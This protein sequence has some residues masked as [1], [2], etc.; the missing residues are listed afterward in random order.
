MIKTPMTAGASDR[1]VIQ[2]ASFLNEKERN[3]IAFTL[4]RIL[5]HPGPK[6]PVVNSHDRQV[7]D[8]SKN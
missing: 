6:G 8:H 7:V 1:I 5:R 4:V 2:T 3:F